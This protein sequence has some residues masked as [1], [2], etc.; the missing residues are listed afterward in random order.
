MS[1]TTYIGNTQIWY[2]SSIEN[3]VTPYD[4]DAFGLSLYLACLG[5]NAGGDFFST[6]FSST[7]LMWVGLGFVITLLPV[8]I[9]GMVSMR[10][11]KQ[12]GHADHV[13]ARV[14]RDLFYF[15]QQLH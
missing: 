5:L 14:Q 2:K 13:S 7:G 4:P 9:M 6:A 11:G 10:W 3:V 8:L 15:F 1:V 12:G